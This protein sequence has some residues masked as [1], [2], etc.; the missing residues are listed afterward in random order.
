VGLSFNFTR[1]SPQIMYVSSS[2]SNFGSFTGV[3]NKRTSETVGDGNQR[4]CI[5]DS[6]FPIYTDKTLPD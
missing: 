5:D 4:H 2:C 6:A 1:A 3:A